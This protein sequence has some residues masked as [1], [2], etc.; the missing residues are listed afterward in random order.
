MRNLLM[1]AAVG[2]ILLMAARG[3][4]NPPQRED[5]S[6]IS[7]VATT[8]DGDTIRIDGQR[9]RIGAIDACEI[10]QIGLMAGEPWDC[11]ASGRSQMAGMVEGRSVACRVFDIDRYER[12]V[13]QCFAD[14][15]DI[16]LAMVESGQAF[17]VTHW[18]PRSHPI[19]LDQY[20]QIEGQA[21]EM[22][23]GIWSAELDDP[24]QF[25]SSR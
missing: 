9:I 10:G 3:W 24:A 18:L 14:E 23:R 13:A 11:G 17:V 1:F 21:R 7:G 5:F 8:V 20:R 16:G 6:E 15:K 22:N 2:F 12:P 4:L 19:D 25:R